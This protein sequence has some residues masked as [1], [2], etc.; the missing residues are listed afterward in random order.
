MYLKIDKSC[1]TFTGEMKMTHWLHLIFVVKI[2]Q[3][4]SCVRQ[5]IETLMKVVFVEIGCISTNRVL[6]DEPIRNVWKV[7]RTGMWCRLLILLHIL[8]CEIG[9]LTSSEIVISALMS[10]KYIYTAMSFDFDEKEGVSLLTIQLY[11]ATIT[12]YRNRSTLQVQVSSILTVIT[13]STF[14]LL[15]LKYKDSCTYFFQWH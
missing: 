7:D 12:T 15:P 3:I 2:I 10:I 1:H 11:F 6:D 9:A 5:K 4:P 13:G 8:G 14:F